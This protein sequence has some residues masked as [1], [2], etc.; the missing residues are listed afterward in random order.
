V[1]K[2]G[3]SIVCRP[4]PDRS[5][6][7][8]V[9]P[10]DALDVIYGEEGGT[11]FEDRQAVFTVKSLV[12]RFS[13][14]IIRCFH[15]GNIVQIGI[16][17]AQQV[18]LRPVDAEYI[19]DTIQG[20]DHTAILFIGI[21]VSRPDPGTGYH[22]FPV[23]ILY[24]VDRHGLRGDHHYRRHVIAA[25]LGFRI[26]IDMPVFR[27]IVRVNHLGPEIIH[28]VMFIV[29][30]VHFFA[31]EEVLR[32]VGECLLFG[33]DVRDRFSGNGIGIPGPGET[34]HV[35]P[36]LLSEGVSKDDGNDIIADTE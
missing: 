24:G 33:P 26:E 6:H 5:R 32:D 14:E 10:V 29:I 25:G 2:E 11:V 30:L 23:Y 3:I 31:E 8:P 28:A 13:R 34:V 19:F 27:V 12:N 9:L 1:V 18:F 15:Q 22:I 17:R 7:D 21:A 35:R 20:L 4:L 16:I 36:D